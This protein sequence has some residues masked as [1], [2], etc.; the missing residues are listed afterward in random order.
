MERG[1][2]HLRFLSPPKGLISQAGP[3]RQ[4]G[5][6]VETGVLL[7]GTGQLLECGLRVPPAPLPAVCSVY[8]SA[9]A[10]YSMVGAVYWGGHLSG[11]CCSLLGG[12][13]PETLCPCAAPV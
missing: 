2:N 9:L 11:Q 10:C 4:A 13:V 1:L 7:Q 3:V 12:Y 8:T 5:A 6:S